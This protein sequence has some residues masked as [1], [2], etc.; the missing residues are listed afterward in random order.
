M[1]TNRLPSPKYASVTVNLPV[2]GTFTYEIPTALHSAIAVGMRVLVPFG[3]R[4]IT[5]FVIE[6]P[7]SVPKGVSP[8]KILR[9][10]DREPMLI[11]ELLELAGWISHYYFA[12]LGEVINAAMPKGI[13]S[14]S[15]EIVMITEKGRLAIP[16]IADPI[17]K[18]V[19]ADLDGRKEAKRSTLDKK[20]KGQKVALMLKRFSR[21]GLVKLDRVIQ[22]ETVRKRSERFYFLKKGTCSEPS[23]I[24]RRSPKRSEMLK[25][26]SG[27]ERSL[28]EIRS[29]FKNP[30]AI[31]NKLLEQNLIE[32]SE[33]TRYRSPL[34][35]N[36]KLEATPEEKK[37]LT[38]DQHSVFSKIFEWIKKGQSRS[39]LLHG[40]TGSG[41][42]EIY[43][44]SISAVIKEGKQAIVLV[45]EISL[46][47]QMISRFHAR[48]GERVALLHS[49]LSQGERYDEWR[50]I[51]KGEV[52]IAVGARSAIF[53]PFSRLGI[54][55]VDEE[56]ET[57]FK[58][59]ESPRYHAREAALE[60][61]K[62]T[63]AL[64]I[65]GSATPSLESIRNVH[66][67]KHEYLALNRRISSHPMPVIEMVD[68]RS[69]LRG[70]KGTVISEVLRESIQDA[71]ARK[72]QIFLFLNRRG[73]SHFLQCKECG[74]VPSCPHCSV[75]LTFHGRVREMRC[76]YCNYFT[77]A[78]DLC[79]SCGGH[80]ISFV[81][82]GTQKLED[83]VKGFFPSA[84]IARMDRD[85][86][87]TKGS[88]FRI[89]HMLNNREIDIL[90]GTQMIAKGHDFPNVTLVGIVNADASIN[91]PDFRS[92]ERTFQLI[93]Q[94][95]GRAGRGEK[96][97]RV[98][99]QSFN[100][101]YY[102]FQFIAKYDFDGFCQK[103]GK[104]R[105]ALFY[106]PYSKLAALILESKSDEG[107][108]KAA[109]EIANYLRSQTPEEK[110][111]EILGPSQATI[112][113]VKNIYRWRLLLKGK[114]PENF[115]R[116]L[117]ANFPSITQRKWGT[118]G[119]KISIDID[120]AHI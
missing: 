26:L 62:I 102:V 42:T 44:Q 65:L 79:P 72:E 1:I 91:I 108:K 71:L 78:P 6:Y 75:T 74:L 60:R 112:H 69:A 81:G 101:D 48:F 100:P 7:S 33:K 20:F 31:L 80:K 67:G 16:Y 110:G 96:P 83:E 76:H 84:R 51:K 14:K 82:C 111:I 23:H 88:F 118:D 61:G 13:D 106:P 99:V 41:K 93:A 73:T 47:P 32:Y 18:L 2:H 103:E 64:V 24:Q 11:R 77:A 70:Q 25:F 35:E 46:T 98:I 54:I 37:S 92:G 86:V 49:G 55:I 21:E 56:H 89:F 29:V 58:Q 10:P 97:G 57:S 107:G 52:D 4:V 119:V 68:M 120:P 117:C 63:G 85:A 38:P 105:A 34:K 3:K 9:I 109:W 95:A 30:S 104:T 113:K 94:V 8:K 19:L 43:L 66:S 27:G 50:R 17:G 59:E 53:A 22:E 36:F 39:F 87:R 28:S 15:V 115:K 114:E 40:V 12:P 5:A 45:P 116:F 90:I